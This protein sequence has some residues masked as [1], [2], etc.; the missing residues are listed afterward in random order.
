MSLVCSLWRDLIAVVTLWKCKSLR[1]GFITKDWNQSVD[2]WKVFYFLCSLQRN[3]LWN[4]C[5]EEKMRSWRI[6][7]YY[8]NKWKS[9][10][11]NLK[12]EGYWDELMDNFR[13]DIVVKD[14]FAPR[15]YCGPVVWRPWW[16]DMIQ[17][18][19]LNMPLAQ[20]LA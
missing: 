7:S 1:E 3:L 16:S 15:A 6:D 20:P 13:P 14:W 19:I 9:Q 12:A 10:M 8:R 17:V 5:A 11:V 18:A 4:P 2:D